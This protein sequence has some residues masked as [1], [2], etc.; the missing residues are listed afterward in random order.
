MKECE[1]NDT[2]LVTVYDHQ[3][4]MELA[5]LLSNSPPGGWIGASIGENRTKKWSNGDEVTFNSNLPECCAGTRCVTM[6]AN[7]EWE[8]LSCNETKHFMCYKQGKKKLPYKYLILLLIKI[9]FF[10]LHL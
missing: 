1:K 10:F 7:G 9:F 4:N 3:D 8:S 6:K 5:K 2:Q